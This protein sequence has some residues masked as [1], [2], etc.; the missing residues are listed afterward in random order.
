MAEISDMD[1]S[2]LQS[3]KTSETWFMRYQG[4]ALILIAVLSLIWG[5]FDNS[6]NEASITVFNILIGI[7]LA[8]AGAWT[9]WTSYKPARMQRMVEDFLGQPAHRQLVLA[10]VQIVIGILFVLEGLRERIALLVFGI[11]LFTIAGWA[12][13]RSSNIRQFQE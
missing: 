12:F 3:W 8:L 5:F 13:R 7:G 9:L 11:L 1:D 6:Y 2:R 10:G 4:G